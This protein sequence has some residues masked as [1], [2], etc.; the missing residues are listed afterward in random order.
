MCSERI[1]NGE[2]LQGPIAMN[3][4]IYTAVLASACLS[5]FRCQQSLSNGA[6][7]TGRDARSRAQLASHQ[8]L[9]AAESAPS[10][11]LHV[12]P[13]I[14]AGCRSLARDRRHLVSARRTFPS[15][16]APPA[17]RPQVVRTE[18]RE[19]RPWARSRLW[20]CWR[21][22]RA[23]TVRWPRPPA[24][25]AARAALLACSALRDRLQRS[26]PAP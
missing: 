9:L 5:V 24:H 13:E 6:L 18:R 16:G 17:A 12:G 3:R 26:P 23:R 8:R 22:L 7:R 2:T 25:S 15:F 21:W 4:P 19:A 1:R 11:R 14:R 10:T 20:R